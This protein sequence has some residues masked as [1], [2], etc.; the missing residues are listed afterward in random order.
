MQKFEDYTIITR[1]YVKEIDQS[2]KTYDQGLLHLADGLETRAPPY[3]KV[4]NI[5]SVSAIIVTGKKYR[6]R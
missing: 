5:I 4:H 3:Y 1:K 6:E 2:V